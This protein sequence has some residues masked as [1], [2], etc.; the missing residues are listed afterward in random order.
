MA[1]RGL[2]GSGDYSS[3]FAGLYNFNRNEGKARQDAADQDAADRWANGLM[4]DAEWLAYIATAINREAGDPKRQQQWITAQRKYSSLIADKQAEQAYES[5]GPISDLI[6]HYQERMSHMVKDSN[7]YRETS[8]RVNDLL[9]QRSADSLSDAAEAMV[10]QIN[11]GKKTYGDLKALLQDS[12][13]NTRPN[14]DLRKSIEKQIGDID[15]TL[16]TNKLEGSFEKLQFEYDA[17]KIS[18]GTYAH[19]LRQMAGQFKDNDP[20]RYYQI[21]EAAVALEKQ[22]AAGGGSGGSGGGGGRRGGS[23]GGSGGGGGRSKKSINASIDLLQAKRNNLQSLVEQFESGASR[24]VDPGTGQ[25]VV[26]NDGVVHDIDTKLVRIFDQ[27]SA[28]YT[29]KGDKSA[30]ANTQKSKSYFLTQHAVAHNTF[31]VQDTR[32]ELM[33]ASGKLLDDALDDP[34]PAKG[35]NKVNEVARNW[36]LFHKSLTEKAEKSANY[37]GDIRRRL[38]GESG[39]TYYN[40]KPKAQVDQVDPA[41]ANEAAAFSAALRTIANPAVTDEEAAAAMTT[42]R[43]I[44]GGSDNNALAQMASK[45]LETASRNQGLAT[46]DLVRIATPNGVRWARTEEVTYQA[47]DPG[48]NGAVMVKKKIPAQVRDGDKWV[49]LEVDGKSAKLVDIYVDINGSPTKMQAVAQLTT[50]QGF[51]TWYSTGQ[52]GGGFPSNRPLTAAQIDKILKAKKLT[53]EQ[54]VDTGVIGTGAAFQSWAVTTPSYTDKY[55]KHHDSE[56]WNQDP[57]TGLWYKGALPIRGV[58]RDA[59]GM[60]VFDENGPKMD[61]RSFASAAGV[62]APY[63]GTDAKAMQDQVGS[64]DLSDLKSR[65]LLGEVVD[66]APDVSRAYFSGQPIKAPGLRERDS[67]WDDELQ[68][69]KAHD[70]KTQAERDVENRKRPSG[71]PFTEKEAGAAV[72]GAV[73]T[74]VGG[75]A[76]ALGINLGGTQTRPS[77][78]SAGKREDDIY[79]PSGMPPKKKESAAPLVRM[80]DP[81]AK[82]GPSIKAEAPDLHLPAPTKA[83]PPRVKPNSTGAKASGG[84]D[85]VYKPP[86]KPKPKPKPAPKPAPA[87]Q[88]TYKK[89]GGYLS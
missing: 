41:V 42:L 16:R 65:G 46:G 15:E 36:E 72:G 48:G 62:P 29:E 1:R 44:A 53:L 8:L 6:A 73:N 50:P 56:V 59:N 86:P 24:G 2:G 22:G 78:L 52:T 82:S 25:V 30:A 45:A 14:S 3:Y 18:G 69:Q 87:P 40:G 58:Q 26:F 81:G 32:R 33:T 4:S 37:G 35:L 39:E 7:E 67:W 21:L 89:S 66:Q 75:V 13:K 84:K 17:G 61:W 27:L 23:G 60:V 51:D 47:P 10:K 88:T 34:D 76:K 55:G 11:A 31:A 49:D 85:D 64:L 68:E 38:P 57:D 79:L 83:A 43:S 12:L 63:A 9:D 28:A 77:V 20:K 54:A 74:I 80:P 71:N 70:L 5:G 19:K